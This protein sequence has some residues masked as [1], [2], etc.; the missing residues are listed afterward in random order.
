MMINILN[1][2]HGIMITSKLTRILKYPY[3]NHSLERIVQGSNT[4]AQCVC[5]WGGGGG[6]SEGDMWVTCSCDVCKV[7]VHAALCLPYMDQTP[8]V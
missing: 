3:S 5:V 1:K 7:Y 4:S 2:F 6:G 8:S